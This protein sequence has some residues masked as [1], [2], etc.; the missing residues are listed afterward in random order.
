MAFV[1][2]D[3]QR[4]DELGVFARKVF[5]VA[6][7]GLLLALL[8]YAMWRST[9]NGP[10]NYRLAVADDPQQ[11]A[12]VRGRSIEKWWSRNKKRAVLPTFRRGASRESFE[13]D[14][15]AQLNQLADEAGVRQTL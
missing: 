13:G 5:V 11:L 6:G 4:R 14:L 12:V 8:C 10:A 2:R 9:F 1:P 15:Q 3:P 7:V